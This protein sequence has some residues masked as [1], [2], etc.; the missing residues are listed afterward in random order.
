MNNLDSILRKYIISASQLNEQNIY[1]ESQS[2]E[3]LNRLYDNMLDYP[4]IIFSENSD[5]YAEHN[6]DDVDLENEIRASVLIDIEIVSNNIDDII[7]FENLF[8][9]Q[10]SSNYYL[11]EVDSDRI[12]KDTYLCLNTESKPKRKNLNNG[13]FTTAITV[14]CYDFILRKYIE[15]PIRFELDKNAQVK[16]LK[17]LYL[18]ESLYFKLTVKYN[19]TNDSTIKEKIGSQIPLLEKQISEMFIFKDLCGE[20]FSY[21]NHSFQ[22]CY[23]LLTDKKFNADI[24]AI[25]AL[26]EQRIKKDEEK[27]KQAADE[28]AKKEK[29]VAE[30]LEKMKVHFSKEGDKQLNRYTDAVIQDFQSNIS[31]DNTA[32]YGGTSFS[33]WYSQFE[34]RSLTYPNILIVDSFKYEIGLH[35]YEN[36]TTDGD[37]VAHEYNT[38][39]LPVK[40]G[41]F[42]RI[43]SNS[44]EKNKE[45]EQRIIDYYYTQKQI[46][47]S[48]YKNQ[49]ELSVIN[50]QVSP[51][52]EI[53]RKQFGSVHR[54][55]I[56]FKPFNSIFYVCGY[57]PE[58][59]ENNQRQQ[60]RLL[61]QAEYMYIKLSY[62]AEAKRQLSSYYKPLIER[63][64]SLLGFLNSADYKKVKSLYNNGMPI[65]KELFDSAM[66]S[67]VKYYPDLYQQFI[68]GWSYAQI[69]Q[70]M[71][72]FIN[73][74]K[75]R[76]D[77]LMGLLRIPVR[78]TQNPFCRDQI[79]Y[80]TQEALIY[81]IKKMLDPYCKLS[82][83]ISE[84]TTQKLKE[85]EAKR[86][87]ERIE[88]E[89]REAM[90][91]EQEAYGGGS[92]GSGI[93]KT[94]F[95]VALGNKISGNSGRGKNAP[96]RKDYSHSGSCTQSVRVK[97]GK[98]LE[99]TC[100]GCAM[101]PYCT[102][103]R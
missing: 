79:T 49:G 9:N 73:Y 87:R 102:R 99:R 17:H 68:N 90:R 95:G 56:M 77:M 85:L 18:L 43:F 54:T 65:S 41:I 15:N 51:E 8:S 76:F 4:A 103:Y 6:Q 31:L 28:K 11:K 100:R 91:A 40:Y 26:D 86:E 16:L 29:E 47:V 82:T 7:H 70:N 55:I 60:L 33:K 38:C 92:S 94:A 74:Y 71:D 19:S 97:N 32:I 44:A 66:K 22:Y 23:Q 25:F 101:A 48:D 57:T 21:K 53:E 45:L 96:V 30:R 64:H 63:K 78:S 89:E 27:R 36:E 39:C 50:L 10:L 5:Y 83:A 61:Q 35:S 67:I 58:E 12:V 24:K 93:L 2:E 80:H 69:E 81:F 84:Y 3:F 42:V 20:N 98:I 14:N 1:L 34:E 13:T 75:T 59:C 88:R 46:R 52:A 72:G 62:Y 37:I